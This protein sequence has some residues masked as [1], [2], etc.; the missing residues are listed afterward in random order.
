MRAGEYVG[1]RKM[2]LER[3]KA[4]NSITLSMTPS[5]SLAHTG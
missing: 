2:G 1:G 3:V 4:D 5:V